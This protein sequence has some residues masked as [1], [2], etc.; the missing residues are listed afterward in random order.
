MAEKFI[1][2]DVK[3]RLILSGIREI[4]EN[5]IA[6]FSL[7]R[8]AE[9]AGVSCAAPYRHFKSKEAYISNVYS[10]LA[11]MWSLMF[12]EIDRSYPFNGKSVFKASFLAYIKFWSANKNLRS[13]ITFF[14]AN[15]EISLSGFDSE[16]FKSLEDYFSELKMPEE[17]IKTKVSLLRSALYGYIALFDRSIVKS[18]GDFYREIEKSLDSVLD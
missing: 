10:Y 13:A 9:A 15:L 12:S 8:A 7:R 2:E 4:E 3:T 14:G 17:K 11:G 1:E 18:D 6:D 5:G 16:I